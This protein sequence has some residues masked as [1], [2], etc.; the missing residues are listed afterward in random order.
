MVRP[1]GRAIHTVLRAGSAS[2]S[3]TILAIEPELRS[4]A[5]TGER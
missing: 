2:A 1:S 4:H 5:L 3:V